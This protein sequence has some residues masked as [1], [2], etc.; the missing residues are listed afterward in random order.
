MSSSTSERFIKIEGTLARTSGRYEIHG[1]AARAQPVLD[2]G[3][4]SRCRCQLPPSELGLIR[5]PMMTAVSCHLGHELET[6]VLRLGGPGVFHFS[7][8]SRPPA[9]DRKRNPLR[10]GSDMVRCKYLV[11]VTH[12]AITWWAGDLRASRHH[13]GNRQ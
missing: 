3:I 1:E 9:H 4:V 13:W 8:T 2:P 7:C 6:P 12:G 10:D 11:G 5:K